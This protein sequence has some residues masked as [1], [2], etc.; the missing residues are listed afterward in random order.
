MPAKAK[1]KEVFVPAHTKLKLYR[2]PLLEGSIS[3]G[4]KLGQLVHWPAQLA[5]P[6]MKRD[7]AVKKKMFQMKEGWHDSHSIMARELSPDELVLLRNTISE[8]QGVDKG[9][10][11][12]ADR[13]VWETTM[14]HISE[15]TD[16]L[17]ASMDAGEPVYAPIDGN[18]RTAA[19]LMLALEEHQDTHDRI[20]LKTTL[21]VV[22]HVHGSPV[23]LCLAVASLLNETHSIGRQASFIDNLMYWRNTVRNLQLSGNACKSLAKLL[24]EMRAAGV[25]VYTPAKGKGNAAKLKEE[26]G[27]PEAHMKIYWE[28]LVHID[29]EDLDRLTMLQN[30]DNERLFHKLCATAASITGDSKDNDD[31]KMADD[32]WAGVFGGFL[33]RL[34]SSHCTP[35][36]KNTLVGTC[37][38]S[39]ELVSFVERGWACW[40][41]SG[42]RVNTYATWKEQSPQHFLASNVED[43]QQRGRLMIAAVVLQQEDL[44]FIKELVVNAPAKDE[45]QEC[46]Y[47]EMEF[48]AVRGKRLLLNAMVDGWHNA[49]PLCNQSKSGVTISGFES[50]RAIGSALAKRTALLE[51]ARKS[52][53]DLRVLHGAAEGEDAKHLA[54][55]AM[56]DFQALALKTTG[57]VVDKDYG[58]GCQEDPYVGMASLVGDALAFGG[59]GCG[60][61]MW[62]DPKPETEAG[63]AAADGAEDDEGDEADEGDPDYA[64][65]DSGDENNGSVGDEEYYTD[66]NPITDLTDGAKATTVGKAPVVG[67]KRASTPPENKPAKKA[68]LEQ[69]ETGTGAGGTAIA[70][71]A[72]PGTGPRASAVPAVATDPVAPPAVEGTAIAVGVEPGTGPRASAVPAVATDPVAPPAVEGTA[73]V[74]TDPVVAVPAKKAGKPTKATKASKAKKTGKPTKAAKPVKG[75]QKGKAAKVKTVEE[76]KAEATKRQ[77]AR[78][79]RAAAAKALKTAAAKAAA[80]KAVATAKIRVAAVD[81]AKKAA[82]HL[83]ATKAAAGDNTV[84]SEGQPWAVHQ[85]FNSL[86]K[87]RHNLPQPMPTTVF[88]DGG[89]AGLKAAKALVLKHRA[90]NKTEEKG[91]KFIQPLYVSFTDYDGWTTLALAMGGGV[92]PLPPTVHTYTAVCE[93]HELENEYLQKW[94]IETKPDQVKVLVHNMWVF[95]HVDDATR[96][97]E[98]LYMERVGSGVEVDV[99]SYLSGMVSA[100]PGGDCFNTL[101][102]T[103]QDGGPA[104]AIHAVLRY[105]HKGGTIWDVSSKIE[106][107]MNHLPMC[108]LELGRSY[109]CIAPLG[110]RFMHAVFR[111]QD[112]SFLHQTCMTLYDGRWEPGTGPFWRLPVHTP[113]S[114][115]TNMPVNTITTPSHL[116]RRCV[117]SWRPPSDSTWS[118]GCTTRSH[119]KTW[120]STS[121]RV[122]RRRR[123][124]SRLARACQV[125]WSAMVYLPPKPG[126]RATCFVSSRATGCTPS[127]PRR[128][129]SSR[130]ATPTASLLPSRRDGPKW[131]PWCT[132][133]TGAWRTRSTRARSAMRYTHTFTRI[134]TCT[135]HTVSRNNKLHPLRCSDPSTASWSSATRTASKDWRACS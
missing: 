80:A 114:I 31:I 69:V 132:R 133:A 66:E 74:V 93:E 22:P 42:G 48:L 9:M 27:I 88:F 83:A 6:V 68:A 87:A 70:V 101:G 23:S 38:S 55:Q 86:A 49:H 4:V 1:Q 77:N 128:R 110:H 43:E 129:S 89:I 25:N 79:A 122:S 130:R 17:L 118:G 53:Y 41:E 73:A 76:K 90:A 36:R 62:V 100:Q 134:H 20:T 34:D 103:E 3:I 95:A 117:P 45:S 14:L 28:W 56:A 12:G 106:H 85:S 123:P 16:C 111:M 65:G 82:P 54:W 108:A 78:R 33:P 37:L 115:H 26:K 135:A 7:V 97:E 125:W 61:L 127:W 29:D 44:D 72:E 67:A 46:L 58:V 113:T 64:E 13:G 94:I 120:R 91:N 107:N 51:V 18:H 104:F 92:S 52:Y 81:A 75:G 19:L 11:L 35:C 96:R 121:T 5:R 8:M 102:H 131:T 10:C 32:R 39:G 124:P 109:V 2:K 63:D 57:L 119:N 59:T 84:G 99:Q 30:I 116:C 112:A 15:R 24:V 40:V 21:P 98:C 50:E 60:G 71:G 126:R 47:A 105:S